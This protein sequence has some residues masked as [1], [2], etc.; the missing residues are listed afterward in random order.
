MKHAFVWLSLILLSFL[1]CLLISSSHW[2]Q[3]Q[4]DEHNWYE[5]MLFCTLTL[6]AVLDCR[7]HIPTPVISQEDTKVIL[8]LKRIQI[9]II[10]KYTSQLCYNCI[11]LIIYSNSWL[12]KI[13]YNNIFNLSVYKCICNRKVGCKWQ[14]LHLWTLLYNNIFLQVS[15]K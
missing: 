9:L 13:S 4:S 14:L 8:R 6:V 7:L 1:V 12:S 15:M 5:I 11:S 2:P 3:R 10:M